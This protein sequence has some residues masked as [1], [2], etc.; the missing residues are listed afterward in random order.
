MKTFTIKFLT[1]FSLCAFFLACNDDD[2]SD[3]DPNE[4]PVL[5]CIPDALLPDLIAFY[6]FSNGSLDDFSGNG[7]H[8]TNPTS[9]SP[10]T[11]RGGNPNCAFE[12]DASQNEF[13]TYVNP[14]FL[15]DLDSN[16]IT[17][18]FWFQTIGTRD[19]GMYEQMIGRDTGLHCPDTYGQW[20]ISL[21]D[22]RNGVF[23]IN[24]YSLWADGFPNFLGDTNCSNNPNLNVWH[25]IAVTSDGT[26]G[27]IN[28]FID[29]IATTSV[30]GTGCS[31]PLGTNNIG[32]LFLGKQFTGLLDDVAIF[33]R[34]LTTAEIIQ[35][36]DIEPCCQE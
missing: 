7:Y 19:G 13:L 8:L 31:N 9:A 17:I 16:P 27:G 26:G 25:H 35:L 12:F 30:P 29:G 15:N 36:K 5:S 11:D 1:F 34:V 6:S 22:C 33:D 32:D 23:G 14:G 20:S 2:N 28:M 10:G 21:S 18:S 24:D 4:D 3:S